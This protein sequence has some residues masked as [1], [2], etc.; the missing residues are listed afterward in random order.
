M[1][2]CLYF[3]Q[4]HPLLHCLLHLPD[5]LLHCHAPRLLQDSKRR[6]ADLDDGGWRSYRSVQDWPI[7]AWSISISIFISG[8]NPA[9]GF[10]PTPPETE[11]ESTLIWFRHVGQYD[12]G[13]IFN[14]WLKTG[15][16]IVLL[17]KAFSSIAP[18]EREDRNRQGVPKRNVICVWSSF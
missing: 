14:H 4:D 6:E 11:I 17:Q 18:I 9:M 3:S 15:I 5:S 13:G 10:R 7:N 16:L 2:R 8:S 12:S 1:I